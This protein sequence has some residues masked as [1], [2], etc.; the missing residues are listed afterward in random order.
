MSGDVLFRTFW[1]F[2]GEAWGVP[3]IIS[4]FAERRLVESWAK[5]ILIRSFLLL[6][7]R[8]VV[9]VVES[10]IRCAVFLA[11]N[12]RACWCLVVAQTFR[13]G[14]RFHVNRWVYGYFKLRVWRLYTFLCCSVEQRK[15][16]S[17]QLANHVSD[18]LARLV[19]LTMRHSFSLTFWTCC[20]C[21]DSFVIPTTWLTIWHIVDS[22]RLSMLTC[23]ILVLSNRRIWYKARPPW[24]FLLSTSSEFPWVH[25]YSEWTR[26]PHKKIG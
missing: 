25:A 17:S 6:F 16:Q 4:S 15:D 3:I 19:R 5:S 13:E 14:R 2:A 20:W 10:K 8:F 11:F 12:L 24:C 21:Y 9:F 18:Q 23:W 26:S 7:L 22:P 1:G